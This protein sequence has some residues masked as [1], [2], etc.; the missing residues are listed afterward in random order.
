MIAGC[1]VV[2]QSVESCDVK[3]ACQRCVV[4]STSISGLRGLMQMA[5]ECYKAFL[6]RRKKIRHT[7]TNVVEAMDVV[8]KWGD[9]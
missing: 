8:E 1:V 2:I 4:K 5:D 7:G 3:N 9:S 6:S